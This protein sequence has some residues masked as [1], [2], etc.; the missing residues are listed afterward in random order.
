MFTTTGQTA[1]LNRR[2]FPAVV[3]QTLI[4]AGWLGLFAVGTAL[5]AEAAPGPA[6]LEL[7]EAVAIALEANASLAALDARAAALATR[8][9]QAAALPDP[10]LGFNA[11]NLPTD[12][13]DLD[14]EPMTQMQLSFSQAISL[15][16]KR[17]LMRQAAELEADAARHDFDD[18]ELDLAAEV[19]AAWWRLFYLDRAL[20]VV[21]QNQAL[22]RDFV[23]IAQSKYRVGDGLQQD[24]LL[25]QLELSRLFDRELRLR[26]MRGA[27]ES[28]LNRLLNRAG[29]APLRLPATPPNDVLPAVPDEASLLGLAGASRPQLAADNALLAAARARLDLADKERR[30]DLRVGMAYGVRQ[31]IN[32]LGGERPDLLSLN[33]SVNLPLY[34]RSKQRR[35]V[36]Q[37]AHEVTQREHLRTDML[38]AVEA[39]I[40]RHRFDYQSAAEQVALFRTAI[41][42]Q[43]EQTVES[44]MVG[45]RVNQVDFLNVIN[46]QIML[47][48]AQLSYWEALGNAKAALARLAAAVGEEVLYE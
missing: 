47:Y 3:R 15:P 10:V 17:R 19:R 42:P 39:S 46:S 31:G 37:R 16:G 22:M 26:G 8:P 18:R 6:E 7:D 9:D 24:V 5:G 38:R 14:Q 40:K 25:A 35:A 1:R 44:M 43:A 20:E 12:T 36:E 4:Q 41:I 11:M 2:R 45:Y 28:M 33:F 13:F 48:N 27:P 32:P 23:E 29:G 30:P 21:A 34:S